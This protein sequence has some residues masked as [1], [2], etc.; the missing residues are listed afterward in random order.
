MKMALVFEDRYKIIIVVTID[1]HHMDPLVRAPINFQE[2]GKTLLF[3]FCVH[4][5]HEIT[6]L[7]CQ[8]RSSWSPMDANGQAFPALENHY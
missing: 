3:D 4:V 8:G 1:G 6:I 2:C 5:P 7:G